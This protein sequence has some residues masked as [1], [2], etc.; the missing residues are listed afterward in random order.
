[1][2]VLPEPSVAA[3]SAV[4]GARDELAAVDAVP[5]QCLDGGG[6]GGPGGGRGGGW[7]GA[8]PGGGPSPPGRSGWALTVTRS[9]GSTGG[10]AA[11]RATW[12]RAR[13]TAPSTGPILPR[14]ARR[15]GGGHTGEVARSLV[16]KRTRQVL[17]FLHV[18]VSLGWMGAGLANVVLAMTA[19]YTADA[20][21]RRVCYQ[22]I[23]TVDAYLVIPGAFTAFASGVVLS[24]VTPWGLTRY[25]WVLSKLVLT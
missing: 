14:R 24:L 13:S 1:M 25:W 9:R 16:G 7:R 20:D 4:A 19:G 2:R 18:V 3:E 10:P 6:V 17:V 5:R 12:R 11:R 22:M 15:P 21:V 8:Q 23:S